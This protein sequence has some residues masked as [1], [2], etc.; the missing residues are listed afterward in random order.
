M[1]LQ[2]DGDSE[3]GSLP[4]NLNLPFAFIAFDDVQ[5]GK[6]GA[7]TEAKRIRST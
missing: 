6:P 4:R 3:G 5:N 7:R 1:S 2:I